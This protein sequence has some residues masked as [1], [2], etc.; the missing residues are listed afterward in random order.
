LTYGVDLICGVGVGVGVVFSN[1]F[2]SVSVSTP[3]SHAGSASIGVNPDSS[4]T[5]TILHLQNFSVEFN[6][7]SLSSSVIPNGFLTLKL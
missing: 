7:G 3:P 1:V 5:Y 4:L 6:F 2:G